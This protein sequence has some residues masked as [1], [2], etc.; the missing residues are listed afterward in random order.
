MYRHNQ[1]TA[2]CCRNNALLASVRV[3]VRARRVL[4]TMKVKWVHALTSHTSEPISY[5]DKTWVKIQQAMG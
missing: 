5:V 3:L 2:H 4:A 1:E